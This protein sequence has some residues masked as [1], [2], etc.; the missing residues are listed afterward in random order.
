MKNGVEKVLVTGVFDIVHQEHRAFLRDAKK[1]GYLVVGVES[2]LR[3]RQIKGEGRPIHPAAIR[4][5][6]L[7]KLAI[8]DEIFVLPELFSSPDDHRLLLA[9]LRPDILAVSAH[10]KH[11]DKKQRLM[12]EIGGRVMIVREHNPAISTTLL[13]ESRQR[14][15]RADRQRLEGGMSTVHKK[16]LKH[17]G[18]K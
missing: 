8:A 3:V 5:E 11:I 12:Q 16:E 7:Q 6:Q 14:S 15:Q 13:L 2:D 1:L 4:V 9:Q 10:T 17:N 18:K